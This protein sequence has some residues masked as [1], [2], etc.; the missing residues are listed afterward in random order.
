MTCIYPFV[1]I[2]YK[3]KKERKNLN[4]FPNWIV[5]VHMYSDMTSMLILE[6]D[7]LFLFINIRRKMEMYSEVKELR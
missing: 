6:Y 3:Y 5:L 1:H 4:D 2:K 7:K